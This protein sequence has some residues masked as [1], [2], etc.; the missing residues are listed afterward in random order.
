MSESSPISQHPASVLDDAEETKGGNEVTLTSIPP[1][2]YGLHPVMGMLRNA[3]D[4]LPD[5]V[6]LHSAARRRRHLRG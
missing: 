5:V 2:S 4:S 6:V 3:I 1:G